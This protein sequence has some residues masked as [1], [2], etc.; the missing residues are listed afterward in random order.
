MP[1]KFRKQYQKIAQTIIDESLKYEF[2]PVFLLSVIQRESVFNP[3]CLG[4]L[5]EVGL[6]QIRPA[7]AEWIAKKYGLKYT[8]KEMLR[9]PVE[10]IRLGT[11]Y[12]D[13]LRGRF[14]NHAQLY[15]SAYNMGK[16]NVDKNLNKNVWPKEYASH[17]MRFYVEFYS[18]LKPHAATGKK[19]T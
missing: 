19:S 2:D 18:T 14:T 5:D 10:N 9:D 12:L 6:M 15:L 1:K 17:V 3:N 7:T 16:R 4:S 8:N 13:Y 11:A